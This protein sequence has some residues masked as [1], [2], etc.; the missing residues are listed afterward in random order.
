MIFNSVSPRYI[1]I[2]GVMIEFLV[3]VLSFRKYKNRWPAQI[4]PKFFPDG[5]KMMK[6]EKKKKFKQ[7][8]F[9]WKKI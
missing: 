7:V 2:T 5:G 4:R 9:R 1:F 6:I 8:S 3:Y